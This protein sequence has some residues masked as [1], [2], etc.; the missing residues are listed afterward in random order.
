MSDDVPLWIAVYAFFGL[1]GAC[2][3]GIPLSAFSLY[4]RTRLLVQKMLSGEAHAV[5]ASVTSK[6][7]YTTRIKS[8]HGHTTQHHYEVSYWFEARR[9]DGVTCRVTVTNRGISEEYFNDLQEGTWEPVLYSE[10]DPQVCRLDRAAHDDLAGTD[11]GFRLVIFMTPCF[12]IGTLVGFFGTLSHA[13]IY[14]SFVPVVGTLVWVTII[15][16]IVACAIRA[17]CDGKGGT[18]LEELGEREPETPPASLGL[19]ELSVHVESDSEESGSESNE[20]N[21]NR[22]NALLNNV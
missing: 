1:W 9:E 2:C 12:L 8:K 13:L 14:G 7:Y 11:G 21:G 5:Y 17:P 4:L 22:N 20:N 16:L 3:A 10:G 19:P 18:E 6:R 15:G